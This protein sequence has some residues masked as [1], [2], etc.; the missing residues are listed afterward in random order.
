MADVGVCVGCVDVSRD[1]VADEGT[2]TTLEEAL[3][4]ARSELDDL[5]V[6][7]SYV[8]EEVRG[9]TLALGRA[10]RAESEPAIGVDRGEAGGGGGS[11][12]PPPPPERTAREIY[13]EL[14]GPIPE[15]KDWPDGPLNDPHGIRCPGRWGGRGMCNC[16]V[17]A[18]AW[19]EEQIRER[20][21]IMDSPLMD[22]EPTEF[23]SW[24]E[25]REAARTNPGLS[26]VVEGEGGSGL[27]R[28][29]GVRHGDAL[30]AP[31]HPELLGDAPLSEVDPAAAAAVARMVANTS[32][33]LPPGFRCPHC[34]RGFATE[35]GR[36]RHVGQAHRR[37][38]RPD[39]HILT[40]AQIAAQAALVEGDPVSMDLVDCG[41]PG[42]SA[43]RS[44]DA[45]ARHRLSMH[46][47]GA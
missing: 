20:P 47:V 38:A 6:R 7:Q 34:P 45:I 15:A 14:I 44:A 8:E 36:N 42:C 3:R 23:P 22:G 30:T 5:T 10:R 12:P 25:V 1:S 31:S 35:A 40:P 26:L 32:D 33:G 28:H 37:H 21:L 2:V 9:L 41:E 39:D 43:R 29:G 18:R 46:G 17:R 16:G 13:D 4:I 19:T 11:E 24:D 27:L